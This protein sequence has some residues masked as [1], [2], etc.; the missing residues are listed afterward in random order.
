MSLIQQAKEN[1]GNSLIRLGGSLKQNSKSLLDPEKDASAVELFQRGASKMSSTTMGGMSNMTNSTT[2]SS[3]TASSTGASCKTSMYWNWYTI[4]ACFISKHWHIRSKSMFVGSIFGIIFMMMALEL[5]RR[6]HREFDRWCIRH[7]R[8]QLNSSCPHSPESSF[9][10]SSPSGFSWF[11]RVC[12]HFIRSCFYIVQFIVTYIA[13]LLAMYY[14]GYVILF[15]FCG[16]FLGYFLF[17]ADTVSTKYPVSRSQINKVVHVA[18]EKDLGLK[19]DSHP[20][21]A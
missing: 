5:I 3:S 16:T 15:L 17:A 8:D 2:S 19:T 6:L 21:D 1:L 18:D 4:D 14:N 20:S 11:T 7:S 12:L 9:V 13:M 10:A